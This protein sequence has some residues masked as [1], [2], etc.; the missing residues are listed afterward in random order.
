[1]VKVKFSLDDEGN[2]TY[3]LVS[4]HAEYADYGSDLICA[5]VSSIIFGLMNGL[6]E[7]GFEGVT[8]SDSENQ[9]E[10][11]NES[12]SDKANDYIELVIYQLKTIEESYGEFI[13]VER[14]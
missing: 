7:N 9:I 2:Y 6:D 8:I 13:K 5:S 10:I 11:I 12:R 14:K 3:L 4:G 1:M